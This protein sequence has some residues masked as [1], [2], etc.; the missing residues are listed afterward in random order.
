M[1]PERLDLS[2]IDYTADPGERERLVAAILARAEPELRR[3]LAAQSPIALLARWVRPTLSAAAVLAA[4]SAAA[5][6]LARTAEELA[7]P[8]AG[9]AEALE[10]PAPVTPWLV[11]E[12][13]PTVS[14][15]ILALEGELP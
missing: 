15:V 9:L 3:R 7:P 10:V 1:D 4:V 2:P 8:G 14:D 12:R 5:L 6:V 13:E 11:G